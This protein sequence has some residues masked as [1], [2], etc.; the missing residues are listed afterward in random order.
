M[1]PAVVGG[2]IRAVL[3]FAGGAGS[4]SDGEIEQVAGAVLL[5]VSIGWSIY[6][7]V[8]AKQA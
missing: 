5:L 3:A 2:I 8:T 6:Q 4:V 1:A 7:K